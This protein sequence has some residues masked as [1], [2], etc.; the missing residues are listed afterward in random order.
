[1]KEAGLKRLFSNVAL[2]FIQQGIKLVLVLVLTIYI[3]RTL[4]PGGNGQY[5]LAILL[6][7][8][9]T[10][11]LILGI[12]SA[13]VFYIGREEIDIRY[14]FYLNLK[15]WTVISGIGTTVGIIIILFFNEILFPGIDPIL[16][17]IAL[18]TFPALLLKKLI[19]SLFQA[20]EKFKRY[21]L[22]LL[23]DPFF[24][25]LL[26]L[27]LIGIF[28]FGVKAACFAFLAGTYLATIISLLLLI[29]YLKNVD[30]IQSRSILKK[31]LTYGGKAHLSNIIT[32]FNYRLD[33]ILVNFFLTPAATGVYVVAVQIAE[34]MWILSRS[35][36]TVLLPK[37]VSLNK[38]TDTRKILIPLVCRWIFWVS[39]MAAIVL[40]LLSTPLIKLLFGNDYLDAA[41]ALLWLLPGIVVG[42]IARVFSNDIAAHGKPEINLYISIIVV[43]CN[44]IANIMLIPLY[45][46]NG[47]AIATTI[48]YTLNAILKFIIYNKINRIKWKE[49][50]LM[51]EYDLELL[52]KI[53]KLLKD[54]LISFRSSR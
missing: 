41:G 11:F 49:I 36:S 42:S 50:F 2:N 8:L 14:S 34:R 44:V 19:V 4:G 23:T 27:I 54:N 51:T 28:H 10:T 38:T 21:N 31:S 29:P 7:T 25:L 46:I 12:D 40:A 3:A 5:N 22:I 39:F 20:I 47:A 53:F 52:Q 30:K 37:L 6:P 15:L 45:G 18:F 35:V 48:S 16:L 26:T 43:F 33:L 17:W 32:F 13:N 9:L 1:M 24:L